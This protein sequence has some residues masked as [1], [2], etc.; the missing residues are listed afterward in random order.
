MPLVVDTH[1][2]IW[3]FLRD[4]RLSRKAESAIEDSLIEGRRIYLPSICLVEMNY[5]VEKGRIPAMAL[6]D[7]RHGISIPVFG[8]VLAP[9]DLDVIDAIARVPRE[10]VP[11]LPDRVIV[12]TALSKSARLI[13]RDRKIQSSVVQTIW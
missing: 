1:V 6:T 8:F 13:S 2:A 5:L 9:L 4:D 12:A 11:D 10:Q 3:Y 7:L